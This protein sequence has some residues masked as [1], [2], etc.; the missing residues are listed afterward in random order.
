MARRRPAAAC[1]FALARTA[2]GRRLAIVI[3]VVALLQPPLT[4]GHVAPGEHVVA[5]G[6]TV[7]RGPDGTTVLTIADTA[8]ARSTLESLRR[9]G[10][11]H[12]ALVVAVD[13][14]RATGE[15]IRAV[16]SRLEIDDLWAPAQ[17]QIRGA[18][19]P[20]IGSYRVGSFD[21]EVTSTAAPLLVMPRVASD[22]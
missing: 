14:G 1:A 20:V 18:R 6:L 11:R 7:T 10:V 12:V 17:H 16:R 21:I 3:A 22:P 19:T 5:T 9:R 4:F 2:A 8:R 15:V 13:G